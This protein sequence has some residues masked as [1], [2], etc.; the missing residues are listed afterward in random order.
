MANCLPYLE[1]ELQLIQPRTVIAVGQLAISRFL[2]AP[3]PLSERIGR[4]FQANL[5]GLAFDIVPLPHPS[6]RSTWLV[7]PE[8]QARL[9]Q[10]LAALA[11]TRG[12]RDTFGR[13]G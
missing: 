5:G 13:R 4:V 10:A 7:H 11:A 9:D 8:N 1:R 2:P 6:G 3:A 12:W